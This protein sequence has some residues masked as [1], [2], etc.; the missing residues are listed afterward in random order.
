LG[1]QFDE[2]WKLV[3]FFDLTLDR[4]RHYETGF[5][6]YHLRFWSERKFEVVDEFDNEGLQLQHSEPPGNARTRDK[7]KVYHIL[8]IQESS[9][10]MPPAKLS[11]EKGQNLNH[12]QKDGG[13]MP[14]RLP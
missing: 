12:E 6:S 9:Y 13:K 11:L 5:P 10:R 8:R 2:Q 4:R 14:H 1:R 7:I 3:T